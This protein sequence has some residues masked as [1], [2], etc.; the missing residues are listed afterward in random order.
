LFSVN[1]FDVEGAGERF[2][3]SKVGVFTGSQVVRI[4][5]TGR[6]LLNVEADGEWSVVVEQ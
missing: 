2:V 6:V 4:E 3:F 1:L 5:A